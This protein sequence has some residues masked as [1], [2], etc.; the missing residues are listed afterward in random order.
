[1]N[2]HPNIRPPRLTNYS[3]FFGQQAEPATS[4]MQDTPSAELTRFLFLPGNS[5]PEYRT[6]PYVLI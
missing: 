1:M 4:P 6:E 2:V 3:L 5:T